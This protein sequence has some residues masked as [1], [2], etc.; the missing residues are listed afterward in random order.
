MHQHNETPY[1]IVFELLSSLS[2][3]S[4]VD[5]IHVTDLLEPLLATPIDSI[6]DNES[7]SFSITSTLR[8]CQIIIIEGGENASAI[9]MMSLFQALV[10][11]E[12]ETI[13]SESSHGN[14]KCFERLREISDIM[15]N[16]TKQSDIFNRNYIL[17]HGHNHHHG[18]LFQ[19]N[20]MVKSDDVEQF[21]TSGKHSFVTD[22]RTGVNK[23]VTLAEFVAPR[24]TLLKCAIEIYTTMKAFLPKELARYGESE[25]DIFCAR[26]HDKLLEVA[27]SLLKVPLDEEDRKH[28]NVRQ[29]ALAQINLGLSQYKDQ[30]RISEPMIKY[31]HCMFPSLDWSLNEMRPC[32]YT[33]FKRIDRIFIRMVKSQNLR[34]KIDWRSLIAIVQGLRMLFV[35]QSAFILSNYMPHIINS[36]LI[37]LVDNYPVTNRGI[38][39]GLH[40]L[41]SCRNNQESSPRELKDAI[42]NFFSVVVMLRV[43]GLSLKVI[44][45]SSLT[46]ELESQLLM[47]G[48]IPLMIT[49][50]T[51]KTTGNISYK[52]MGKRD[53]TNMAEMLLGIANRRLKEYEASFPMCTTE[54]TNFLMALQSPAHDLDRKLEE[55]FLALKIFIICFEAE[56]SETKQFE[57]F[58]LQLSKSQTITTWRYAIYKKCIL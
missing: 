20:S 3:E 44:F 16:I 19:K 34:R 24:E 22:D 14:K 23:K 53:L 7:N 4:I 41:A 2:K 29:R 48:I 9:K 28:A 8:L 17:N 11:V 13:R 27:F 38:T 56:Y 39:E 35:K 21:G 51:K 10:F 15:E 58:L 49:T 52:P 37:L 43:D 46:K 57:Q 40:Q 12:L 54:G 50:K 36:L 18:H 32:L 47:F 31:F 30:I 33:F 1:A 25:K 55:I 5:E 26:T 42:A 6:Y 45:Q